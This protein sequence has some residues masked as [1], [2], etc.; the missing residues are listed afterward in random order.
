MSLSS[1]SFIPGTLP[2]II[3]NPIV[4]IL[5][6]QRKATFCVLPLRMHYLIYS[7]NAVSK[8][9]NQFYRKLWLREVK[10][11][12]SWFKNFWKHHEILFMHNIKDQ[13]MRNPSFDKTI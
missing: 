1:L 10:Q 6:T 8:K 11:L 7:L 5:Q 13:M 4:F 3:L 12:V 9:I 2:S